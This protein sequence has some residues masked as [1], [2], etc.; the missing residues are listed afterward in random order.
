MTDTDTTARTDTQATLTENSRVVA[1]IRRLSNNGVTVIRQSFLYQWLTV[2]PDPDVIVIDLRETKIV[3]PFLRLLDWVLTILVGAASGSRLVAVGRTTTAWTRAVPLRAL[4]VATVLGG[5]GIFAVTVVTD[6]SSP[7]ML[8]L[9]VVLIGS[10]AL[11][12]RDRREWETLRD[13]RVVTLL[14]EAFEPPT[15]PTEAEDPPD[16]DDDQRGS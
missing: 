15:P 2:E 4:G 14:I 5:T 8:G 7:V 3:G 11:A 9:A 13:T 16:D 6:S 1:A 10:G 12:M